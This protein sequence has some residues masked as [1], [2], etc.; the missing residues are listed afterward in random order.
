[1][2]DFAVIGRQPGAETLFDQDIEEDA[3]QEGDQEFGDEQFRHDEDV[4]VPGL[5]ILFG[6][7]RRR[8]RRDQP[9]YSGQHSNPC[10]N[11][12]DV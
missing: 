5:A 10:Q 12:I 9:Q 7:L 3:G 11:E 6:R 8:Q 4:G 1:M 2:Q